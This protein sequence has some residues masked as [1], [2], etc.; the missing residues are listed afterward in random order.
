MIDKLMRIFPKKTD[1][2]RDN[3]KVYDNYFT[4]LFSSWNPGISGEEI[5]Q[6]LKV[7]DE[8][9]VENSK[10]FSNLKHSCQELGRIVSAAS[11]QVLQISTLYSDYMKNVE[12]YS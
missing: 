9:C 1:I 10:I 3:I 11:Q 6:I 4:S 7:L 2:I 8:M 5:T 12:K